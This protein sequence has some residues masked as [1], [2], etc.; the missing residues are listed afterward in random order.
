MLSFILTLRRGECLFLYMV[1]K[2]ACSNPLICDICEYVLDD[3]VT[4]MSSDM[5]VSS[6]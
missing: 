4:W 3:E 1:A 2:E 5:L 6:V